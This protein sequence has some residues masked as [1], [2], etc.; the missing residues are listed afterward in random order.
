MWP[1]KRLQRGQRVV[2]WPVF[3]SFTRSRQ[4][5]LIS[6]AVCSAPTWSVNWIQL[7]MII[8]AI[9]A[10]NLGSRRWC[11]RVRWDRRLQMA[12]DCRRSAVIVVV[13]IAVGFVGGTQIFDAFR[14]GR[15][16]WQRAFLVVVNHVKLRHNNTPNCGRHFQYLSATLITIV[17]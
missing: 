17:T 5:G 14:R 6:G 7:R 4:D 9:F 1:Y 3:G 8:P 2:N 13:A 15:S 12:I 16:L 10:I 11:P